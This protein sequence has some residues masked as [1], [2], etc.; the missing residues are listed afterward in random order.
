ML[1]ISKPAG[2][3]KAKEFNQEYYKTY[4]YSKYQNAC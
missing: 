4:T 1:P 3:G 2:S